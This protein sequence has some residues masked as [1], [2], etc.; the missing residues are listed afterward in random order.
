MPQ[1]PFSTVCV[2]GGSLL[3]ANL[4]G[5]GATLHADL[6][7]GGCNRQSGRGGRELAGMGVG[8]CI[9]GG[10]GGVA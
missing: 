10:G 5:P 4:L 3:H 9:I 8:G 6:T 7:I 2:L 1:L